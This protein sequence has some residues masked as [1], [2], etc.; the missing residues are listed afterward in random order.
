MRIYDTSCLKKHRISYHIGNFGIE[1][2]FVSHFVPN[3]DQN[4]DFTSLVF[5][6]RV[7]YKKLLNLKK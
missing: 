7:N 6:L 4:S 1:E 2:F 5:F 3:V